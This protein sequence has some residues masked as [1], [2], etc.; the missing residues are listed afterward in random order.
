[1]QYYISRMAF[2]KIPQTSK[3]GLHTTM[4]NNIRALH[5]NNMEGLPETLFLRLEELYSI[6]RKT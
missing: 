4:P 3:T 6:S 1:M 2:A 5:G